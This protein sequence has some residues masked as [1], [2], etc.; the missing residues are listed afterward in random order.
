MQ[1][2]QTAWDELGRNQG[3]VVRGKVRIV[4]H[5]RKMAVGRHTVAAASQETADP[6]KALR[7]RNRRHDQIRILEKRNMLDPAQ[8]IAAQHTADD[9]A[10][11]DKSV[12]DI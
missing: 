8:H 1:E 9:A 2:I 11:H 4:E 12:V 3:N 6:S 7:E 10:V 5:D